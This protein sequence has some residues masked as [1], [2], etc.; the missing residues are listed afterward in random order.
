MREIPRILPRFPGARRARG[1]RYLRRRLDGRAR[2][3]IRRYRQ[4]CRRDRCRS[5][6]HRFGVFFAPYRGSCYNNPSFGYGGYCLPKCALQPLA[7]YGDVPRNLIETIVE[8][9]RTRK[10]QRVRRGA[11]ARGRARVLRREGAGGG[12][13]PPRHEDRLG[14]L[15][16][17]VGAGYT[18]RMKAKG[19]PVVVYES[20]LDAP[21]FFGS[22][23][24]HDLEAFGSAM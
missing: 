24:T 11:Q 12:R 9:N 8:S 5:L 14:Q 10:E 13:V 1:G 23:V 2:I 4:F 17:E 20:T 18:R 22:E 6:H 3:E 19:V 16:R 21:D 7:N 15:P